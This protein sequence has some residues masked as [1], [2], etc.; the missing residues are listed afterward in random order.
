ML[1]KENEEIPHTC[2]TR[3]KFSL[4]KW[5]GQSGFLLLKFHK[6]VFL[7]IVKQAKAP[8]VLVLILYIS[9]PT[10]FSYTI[11]TIFELLGVLGSCVTA[12]FSCISLLK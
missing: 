6:E 10:R 2:N 11:P 5:L 3:I 12:S 4:L 1:G 8:F 9:S 7:K